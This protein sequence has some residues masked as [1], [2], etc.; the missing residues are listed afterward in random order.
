[1]FKMRNLI[2]TFIH[3]LIREHNLHLSHESHKFVPSLNTSHG[4]M[5]I[6]VQG[7]R[8]INELFDK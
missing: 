4:L 6:T 3:Y 1:M 5:S 8:L 2:K 7:L